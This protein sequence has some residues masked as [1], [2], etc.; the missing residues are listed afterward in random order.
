MTTRRYPQEIS[1]DEADV[2]FQH[3]EL[4][5]IRGVR[6]PTVVVGKILSSSDVLVKL[7]KAR[8]RVDLYT[9]WRWGHYRETPA[10]KVWM[11]ISS[12]RRIEQV[13]TF[14]QEYDFTTPKEVF[15]GDTVG[16]P[17]KYRLA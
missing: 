11:V 16:Q 5:E 1:E 3:L 4:Y 13:R 15:P 2:G 8:D 6:G 7:R 9:H 17:F 12:M 10:V 14:V